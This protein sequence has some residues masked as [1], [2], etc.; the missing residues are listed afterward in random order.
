MTMEFRVLG[1]LEVVHDGERL[2]LGG[3]R[4][5]RVLA[6]LVLDA[7]QMVPVARIVDVLWDDDPPATAAKQARNAV[8]KLRRM[9]AAASAS[10]FVVTDGSGY[11]LVITPDAVDARKFEAMV[12]RG[13][14]AASQGRTREAAG[15]LRSALD[16]WRGPAL[17]GMRGQVI[18]AAAVAWEERRLTALETYLDYELT[19][20]RHQEILGE[21]AG[22]AA[23]HP[24][25]EK[26]AGQHML[27]LYRCG[28]QAD[29][30]VRYRATQTLLAAEMGIEPGPELQRL[31]QQIRA[32]DP[33]LAAPVADGGAGQ[34]GAG[35][36]PQP[37][38]PRQ[39]PGATA[40]FVGREAE[41]AALNCALEQAST[42]G[43]TVTIS[44]VGGTAGVGKTTLAVH[45][46]HQAADHFPDGQ[47]Y[48]NLRGFG[49][50][51]MLTT[52]QEA[53]RGFLDAFGV[54]ARRIPVTQDARAALFRGLLAGRQVLIV[55]DNAR[56]A[57]QVRPL[58]PASPGCVV[59]VTSRSRLTSLVAAEG[60]R[61]LT[62]DM[63]T[64]GEAR[65]LLASRL[66]PGRVAAEPQAVQDIITACA[67]LP[68]ALSVVAARAA[69]NPRFP[70]AALAA[71]L[72]DTLTTGLSGF[73]GGDARTDLRAMF[74]WSCRQLSPSAS[75][76][77]RLI[78][79]HPGPDVTAPAAASLADLTPGVVR[80]L[81]AELA[82]AHLLT[83][84]SPG[85][86]ACHDLLRAYAI[87]LADSAE[88]EDER[89]AATGRMLDHYLHTS[90]TASLLISPRPLLGP[91]IVAP[92]HAGTLPE[93]LAD[94]AAA[95]AWFEA[96][97]QVLLAAIELAASTGWPAHASQLPATLTAYLHRKGRWHD[98]AAA[99]QTALRAARKQGNRAAE[100]RARAGIG[101]AC[102]WLGNYQE[103]RAQLQEAETLFAG[104]GDQSGQ[105]AIHIRFGWM[106]DRENRPADA[107]RHARQ[108]LTLFRAV[109]NRDGQA[110]ALHNIGWYHA[111]LGDHQQ[112]LDCCEQALAAF[113]ELGDRRGTSYAL[114]SIGRACHNL[115]RH[116]E[117]I[118]RY[119]QA[120]ALARELADRY[121]EAIACDHL[122]DSYHAVGQAAASRAAWQ[123][124]LDIYCELGFSGTSH[125]RS[126]LEEQASQAATHDPE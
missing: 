113:I 110:T 14:L 31:H 88:A 125:I 29:A 63:F 94:H 89:Q 93:R 106:H 21:L 40:H 28:R 97:H 20:G 86:F 65:T 73:G 111:L 119:Q 105:A 56:D 102:V 45:W 44:A 17:A 118:T 60:A 1:S 70:L 46:A 77:F 84:H 71:Q 48:V 120:L 37:A 15:L 54:P 87:E 62:V 64:A 76:L 121:G 116:Q 122:G 74:S 59:V 78:G 117:A 98:W 126:K 42:V 124:A 30:L 23:G 101:R 83:E 9:L 96:E 81:L 80:P 72:R 75:R 24:F 104:L 33:A 55:L 112:A 58:L 2:P 123:N 69:E 114:A 67:G 53:L 43:G 13:R 35:P 95:W 66:G 115:G 61:P 8:S 82:D 50:G 103:A 34:P 4:E 16:L 47:L 25:R 6:A 11:R 85:R 36:R 22:L 10:D 12:T 26:L 39:L 5:Q 32:A 38:V 108:A 49:P 18:E 52:P 100:A 68:L 109:G 27:A 41:L 79:L 7:G 19:L 90:H 92:P 51:G 57:E 3:S 107:L 99:Q 91:L